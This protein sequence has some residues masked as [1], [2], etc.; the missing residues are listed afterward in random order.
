MVAA[1]R[2]KATTKRAPR[3]QQQAAAASSE[4]P[5]E[6][7]P[8]RE[9]PRDAPQDQ[10]QSPVAPPPQPEP[11]VEQR[12][13]PIQRQTRPNIIAQPH[14]HHPQQQQQQAQA[15]QHYNPA[16]NNLPYAPVPPP[17]AGPNYNPHLPPGPP[18]P[19]QHPAAYP[20][21]PPP[22][23][24]AHPGAPV[25]HHHSY[26]P[27]S[28]LG[29]PNTVPY[30]PT[31]PPPQPQAYDADHDPVPITHPPPLPPPNGSAPPPPP[32]QAGS[33]SAPANK[34][35]RKPRS[36]STIYKPGNLDS[37]ADGPE[38]PNGRP[39][40][41][42]ST[43][44]RYAIE[45]SPRGMLT[46]AEIYEVVEARFPYYKNAGMGWKN[47]IR[48]NLSLNRIFEKKPRAITEPGKGAYWTI[49]PGEEAGPKR[50][51]K[52]KP[53]GKKAKAAAEAAARAAADAA[54]GGVPSGG[55]YPPPPNG[56]HPDAYPPGTHPHAPGG[57]Y[58][59]E[60]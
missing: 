38:G 13:P 34:P 41:P 1:G 60:Y 56:M 14:P 3:G 39:P 28:A 19:H 6:H 49:K 5:A 24:H 20:H 53:R 43:I 2:R 36:P 46:L 52:R 8:S 22:P 40:Y 29:N 4:A 51:R 32:P 31:Y 15:A 44:I 54:N 12:P 21:P 9:E 10:Q 48:H 30:A 59:E 33:S 23:P 17:T 50:V 11:E 26:Y 58:D 7:Q 47:S 16:L 45:G 57:G 27:Q 18:H 37:L 42:Y 55:M 35:A 25:P